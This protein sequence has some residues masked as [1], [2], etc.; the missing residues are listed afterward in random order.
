M[1]EPDP[2]D[3]RVLPF[4]AEGL[5]VRGRIV[6]LGPAIDTILR[7]HDYPGPVA[8]ALAE[9]TALTLLLGTTLKF[10]GRFI[11]Q[12]RTDGPVRMVVVDCQAPDRVRACATFDAAAVEGAIA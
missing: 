9:A 8:R 12:T 10:D 5:D 7:R 11:L 6:R 4:Q 1:S 3:D 2:V